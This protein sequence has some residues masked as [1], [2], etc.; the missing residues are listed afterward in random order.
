MILF[1][2]SIRDE[3]TFRT[4]L[5]I[6]FLTSSFLGIG[7]YTSSILFPIVSITSL[8]NCLVRICFLTINEFNKPRN[9]KGSSNLLFTLILNKPPQ[10]KLFLSKDVTIQDEPT[11]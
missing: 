10:N 2:A 11:R 9:K 4:A 6:S 7:M 5:L 3:I 1:R 8:V